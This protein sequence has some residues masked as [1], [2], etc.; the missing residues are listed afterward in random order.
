MAKR[1][2]LLRVVTLKALSSDDH[3]TTLSD[4]G[5]LYGDVRIGADGTPA[6]SFVYRFRSGGKTRDKRVGTWP[7]KDLAAIRAERDRLRQMVA[8]GVDPIEQ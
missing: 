5:G 1:E 3:K 6:V 7:A 2:N 8:L 4:G